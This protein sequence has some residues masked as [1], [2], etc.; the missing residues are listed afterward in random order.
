MSKLGKSISIK[1][2]LRSEESVILEGRI[3]GAVFCETR[4]GGARR[5]V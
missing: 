2:E 3:E 4:F 5:D 1:G